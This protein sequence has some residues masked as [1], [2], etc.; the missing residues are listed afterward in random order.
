MID[1]KK[2]IEEI[3]NM[4]LPLVTPDGSSYNDGTIQRK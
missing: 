3:R 4:V 1:K 2:L